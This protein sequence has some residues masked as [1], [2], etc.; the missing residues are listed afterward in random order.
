MSDQ[1]AYDAV[2]VG[3]GPNGLA[4]AI[5]IARAGRSALV[6]EAK[7]TVGGGARTAELTAPGFLHDVCSAIHPMAVGSPF[8]SR[9]PLD[10]Y[11]L[12]WIHPPAP[13]AHPFDDGPAAILERSVTATGEALGDD[14]GTAFGKLPTS[15]TLSPQRSRLG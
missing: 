13:V 8:L 9:L 14:A 15:R 6:I 5:A 3:S 7:E 2:V 4:A 12:E 11:G 10:E 1:R